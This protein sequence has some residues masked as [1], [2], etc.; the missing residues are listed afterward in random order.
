MIDVASG[1]QQQLAKKFVSNT[2][3][4]NVNMK[5]EYESVQNKAIT[6]LKGRE[7]VFNA[8]KGGMFYMSS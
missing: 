5:K 7:V 4:R 1:E 6:F 3:P 8:F 2:R